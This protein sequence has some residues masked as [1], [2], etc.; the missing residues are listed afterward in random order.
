ML[1]KGKLLIIS[2]CIF[3]LLFTAFSYFPLGDEGYIYAIHM[4]TEHSESPFFKH[5]VVTYPAKVIAVDALDVMENDTIKIGVAG[6]TNELN[7]GRVPVGASTTKI[8][9][10]ENNEKNPA[11]L[12]INVKGK[13]EKFTFP[14]KNDIMLK[15][16]KNAVMIK[17]TPKEK[18]NYSGEIEVIISYPKDS[19]IAGIISSL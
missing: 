11:R 13:M 5:S 4:K 19:F 14:E 8:I 9:E 1:T 12:R 16:G 17:C 18:G 3:A 15:P 10:I 6:Q 7:F 2:L